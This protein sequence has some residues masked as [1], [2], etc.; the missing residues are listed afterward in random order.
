ML[1][2]LDNF[3]LLGMVFFIVLPILLLLKKPKAAGGVPVH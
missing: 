3:K 1:A 2:F